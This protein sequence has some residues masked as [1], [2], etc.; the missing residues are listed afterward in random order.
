MLG[1][2]PSQNVAG[3]FEYRV[4][5]TATRT[6]ERSLLFAGKANRSQRT[7]FIAV[8]TGGHAPK[9]VEVLQRL[10]VVDAVGGQPLELHVQSGVFG[11]H[12]EGE[13]QGQ[14]GVVQSIVRCCIDHLG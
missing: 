11:S 3:V 10:V 5:K 13:D 1:I 12:A 14:V 9:A 8:R 2:S 4:L 6:E 7:V